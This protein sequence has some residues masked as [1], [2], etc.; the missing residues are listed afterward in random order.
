[1][2]SWLGQNNGTGASF[3]FFC[4]ASAVELPKSGPGHD[5]I[6][7]GL[8]VLLDSCLFVCLLARPSSS[9]ANATW[10]RRGVIHAI[11]T[12]SSSV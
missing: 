7:E 8:P 10:Q 5:P 11:S 6:I 4:E 3:C 12:L 1:M 9:L 2:L